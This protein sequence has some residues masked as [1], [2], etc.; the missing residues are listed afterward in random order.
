MKQLTLANV[1]KLITIVML[2][3][4]FIAACTPPATQTETVVESDTQTAA[5]EPEES[6]ESA[7]EDSEA[8]TDSEPAAS[9][10]NVAE[11]SETAVE[12]EPAESE[13]S[14]SAMA[15]NSRLVVGVPFLEDILDAQQAFSGGPMTTEQIGQSLLRID[16][17]TGELLPDLAESWE[18][19]ED[20]K[21][22]TFVLPEGA[23]Y[24]NGDP[25]NA[26][27]VADAMFRN[28]EVS[29][30]AS[31]FEALIDVNV[32][33]DTTLALIFSNPPAAFLTVLN[34]TFGGPWNVAAAQAAGNEAFAIN[35]IASGPF[36]VA[37]FTPGSDLLLVRNDNYQTNLPLV[38]NQ[39]PPHLAELLVRMI[40]EGLTLVGEL[41]AGNI[42]MAI[43][44]PV[45]S[46]DRL[47]DNP[48]IT[49][50]ETPQT[51]VTNLAMNFNHPAFSNLLVRQAIA[52]AINRN[53]LIKVVEGALPMYTFITP[54]MVAYSA[55]TESYGQ[56]LHPHDFEAAQ[57]LL[58]EA[59]WIDGDGDGVVEKDGTPF[60]VE[61]LVG[62]NNVAQQQ[63]S[64]VLQNQ[65]K[66]VG[67]D[68]QI[69][70][71]DDNA[72]HEAMVA[73]D[74][75]MGFDSYGWPD[76]D[77]LSLVFAAPFWNFPKYE[78]PELVD[79]MTA[80]RYL[81]DT[82][83][84]TAAYAE[85]QQTLLDDVVEIPLWQGVR[86]TAVR[87]N[88]EGPVFNGFPIFLNDTVVKEP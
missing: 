81:L 15:T 75:D 3:G 64:Q 11:E 87:N 67:I 33:D 50:F 59:G 26:Q 84:R 35:P 39:G 76:P 17:E 46:V 58:T 28:K 1:L 43:N 56:G 83:E 52:K 37:E 70:Q 77:I 13:E 42:D 69:A 55:E 61:I 19:S 40:P 36:M 8:A 45:S 25:L 88:V 44:I 7:V 12:S 86:Y 85:I 6:S 34:S 9:E 60:S 30:Y 79:A 51:G 29:P 66:T 14:D 24:S 4:I 68:L 31:D 20:G 27:A 5:S 53:E 22:M 82:T 80:A 23:V 57:A 41:E 63:V 65:L 32:I 2:C 47:R 72:V 74:Y 78:N 38:E 71:L 18:F 49:V 21:T 10:E 62:A 73:G 16:V 48:E 54:G